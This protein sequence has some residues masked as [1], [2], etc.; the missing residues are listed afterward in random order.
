MSDLFRQLRNGVV[1]AELGGY[2][3]GPY[4]ARHGAGCAL[5]LMGT[6]IVDTG[7][8]VPY[9]PEFV[10]KPGRE[11]YGEYLREHVAAARE[12]GA[13]VAVSVVSVDADDTID[14]LLAS[15]EAGAEYVSVCLHSSMAMFVGAGLS[16]ALLRPEN[17]QRLR[18]RI[19]AYVEALSR[20]LIPKIGWARS[21]AVEEAVD[22]LTALGV[23][24]IHVNVGDATSGAGLTAI[25]TLKARVPFLIVGG[26]IATA[27]DARRAVDAGA[28]AVAVGTAAMDD[29]GL[30]GRL[31]A[32]LRPPPADCS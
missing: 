16:S 4:C 24:I 5:V 18:E 23:E 32:A 14:F 9:S 6:Y 29:S 3:D 30:C 2:G 1:L 11:S 21:P 17:R 7:D 20:P 22:E 8:S 26:G 10:F 27:E 15:E 31:Q 19:G 12:G 28:D 25:E 13:A